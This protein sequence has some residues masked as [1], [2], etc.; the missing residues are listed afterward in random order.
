MATVHS[1]QMPRKLPLSVL[2]CIEQRLHASLHE[3]RVYTDVMA[4]A[5]SPRTPV[6]ERTLQA[7]ST[8]ALCAEQ[9]GEQYMLRIRDIKL[10]QSQT[11]EAMAQLKALL[12]SQRSFGMQVIC[13]ARSHIQGRVLGQG[14]LRML[15][16]QQSCSGLHVNPPT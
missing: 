15:A 10:V 9:E 16:Q 6:Q 12:R 3:A 13:H 8:K 5:R 14:S 4:P 1:L 2:L 11:A 7:P